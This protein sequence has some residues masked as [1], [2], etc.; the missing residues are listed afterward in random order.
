MGPNKIDY[1]TGSWGQEVK[2]VLWPN[3]L[4]GQGDLK[5]LQI[6][7]GVRVWGL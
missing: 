1:V 3:R 7:T 6:L 5:Q 4:L 2:L